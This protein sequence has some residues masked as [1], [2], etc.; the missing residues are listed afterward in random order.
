MLRRTV[1]RNSLEKQHTGGPDRRETSAASPLP[2][3]KCKRKLGLKN[4][5]GGHQG[6]PHSGV[7]AVKPAADKGFLKDRKDL[8]KIVLAP[9]GKLKIGGKASHRKR[10]IRRLW[11]RSGGLL[12]RLSTILKIDPA[13]AAAILCVESTGRGFDKNGKM[14][15]RFENHVFWKYWGK[16]HPSD[17]SAHFKFDPRRPW[18]G[19]K[20]RRS[21]KGKWVSSHRKGQPGEWKAFELARSRHRRFAVY[22]ISMGMPQ[23]MGFNHQTI[24]YKS[25][26]KM[27]DSF[28]GS[29]RNQVVGLFDFIKGASSKMIPALRREDFLTF[30]RLYNG[31]GRAAVYADRLKKYRREFN[32]LIQKTC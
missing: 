18:R 27:F 11:N 4:Q 16:S 2:F 14:I 3:L 20:F 21:L 12:D 8:R 25:V 30:A 23:I 26:Q 7:N 32:G 10:R 28:A 15:I 13:E 31:P 6:A 22:S 17:F 5:G 1:R 29:E 24:G 9:A 19:H